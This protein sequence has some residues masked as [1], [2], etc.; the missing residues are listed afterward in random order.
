MAPVRAAPAASLA[1]AASGP[2]WAE[3]GRPDGKATG[4]DV[5]YDEFYA[6]A[7]APSPCD[8]IVASPIARDCRGV[9]SCH[10]AAPHPR[11][12]STR[13]TSCGGAEVGLYVT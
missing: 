10:R 3:D 1:L 2:A 9:R 13:R 7:S 4:G 8:P 12:R 6:S 5:W 11:P